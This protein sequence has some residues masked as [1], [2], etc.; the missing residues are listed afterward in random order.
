MMSTIFWYITPCSPLSV[1]L[2]ARW[3]LAQLIFF[4]PEDGDAIAGPKPGRER[5]R[6]RSNNL[7]KNQGSVGSG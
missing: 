4:D 3:F 5:R 6:G 1:S 2:L 7:E